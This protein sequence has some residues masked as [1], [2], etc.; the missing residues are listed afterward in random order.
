M[1]MIVSPISRAGGGVVTV[2]RVPAFPEG[3]PV[4]LYADGDRWTMDPV[5]GA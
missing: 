4:D 2:L 3:E 1:L 5:A